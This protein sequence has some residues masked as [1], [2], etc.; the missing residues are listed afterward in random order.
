MVRVHAKDVTMDAMM[1]FGDNVQDEN[2]FLTITWDSEVE[3]S[4]AHM[5]I[6]VSEDHCVGFSLKIQAVIM[7]YPTLNSPC[8]FSEHGCRQSV[9]ISFDKND[10]A[11]ILSDLWIHDCVSKG[12][13]DYHD[14][15]L[16]FAMNVRAGITIMFTWVFLYEVLISVYRMLF[17]VNVVQPEH[18]TPVIRFR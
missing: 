17:V 15:F 13:D 7:R 1:Y 6:S 4:Y 14:K 3:N 5:V 11:L 8:L 12:Y 18:N 16:K 9:I 2:H 10:L